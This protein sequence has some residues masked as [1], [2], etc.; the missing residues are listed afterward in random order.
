MNDR[1]QQLVDGLKRLIEEIETGDQDVLYCDEYCALS[2]FGDTP[3]MVVATHL[4]MADRPMRRIVIYIMA[5]DEWFE[6]AKADKRSLF[7]GRIDLSG[8]GQLKQVSQETI[9]AVR[10]AEEDAGEREPEE[11]V[12]KS[13]DVT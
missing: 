10:Q 1:N 9:S 5:T 8:S 6:E 11:P 2:G 4:G 3:R 7:R 12:D 13:G